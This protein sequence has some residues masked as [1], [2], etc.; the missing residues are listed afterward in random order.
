[1]MLVQNDM[2]LKIREEFQPLAKDLLQGW[3]YDVEQEQIPVTDLLKIWK[4]LNDW[5]VKC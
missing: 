3:G 4:D 1:M 2:R 5:G